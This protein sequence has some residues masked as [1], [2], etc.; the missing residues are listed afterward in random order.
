MKQTKNH[1]SI[2][3]HASDVRLIVVMG[4]RVITN[5]GYK[6]TRSNAQ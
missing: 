5:G 1:T 2:T 3:T 6:I 4:H